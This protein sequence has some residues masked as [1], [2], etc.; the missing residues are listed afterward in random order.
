MPAAQPPNVSADVASLLERFT[1]RQATIGIIGLGY[2]GLPLALT[3]ARAGF[4]VLGFDINASYVERLNRGES[5]IR[6]IP[7]APIKEA[8]AEKRLEATTD[9]TRLGEPDAILI[10]VP[11]PLTK[12]REPDLSY[13]ENTARTIAATLRKGQLIALEST[14]YPGTT[15]EV[16]K[17][18]FEAT[19]LKSGQDF[20]LAF[21][22]ER[23]DPGNPDFGTSTIPKVVGGDGP[24]ALA[25]ADA[26]Y[27][28]LVVK[29]VPVSSAATAEAVKLTE[30]IFRAVNIA[31]VNELKVVYA[32]M[33]IDV[34]EVI[35]AAKTKPFGFMPFY[36]GPGLGGH[37]IPI[38]PFYLTWKAREFDIT[39]R[40]IEL[41]GQVNTHMPYY[42]VEKLAEAVDRSGKAFSGSRILMLG[43]AYKKNVDDMRESPSLKLIELI[44]ARGASVDY[45]DPHIPE[46]PPTRKHGLLAGRRSV[47]LT[48]ET[49]A[50]YDAVLIATDHDNVDYRLVAE[51]ARLVVDT[52]NSLAKAGLKNDR[53][54]KA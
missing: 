44:E 52:R 11:T 9:F 21:S 7:E 15:D 31:L 19:G 16:L 23:E 2:V 46:L 10:C 45:H 35:D 22:P 48:A 12:H 41:A 28:Q 14:T 40:F 50:A 43:A 42:V 29:T 17:P 8:V 13:V 27:T 18:I 47:A 38:D 5:Y 49:L 20:F 24:D 39:T 53:I 51:H 3:A 33:G 4:T 34:W 1:K 6:H 36:P 30:N 32:A 37:C 54:V 26:L 25:L